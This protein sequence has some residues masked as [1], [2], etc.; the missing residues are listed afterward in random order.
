MSN[1]FKEN[2]YLNK[3]TEYFSIIREDI[4]D[5]VPN[6]KENI[7]L[8]IGCGDGGTLFKLKSSH[9]A[10][11]IVGVEINEE[12]V[13][14]SKFKLDKIIIN[15]IETIELPFEFKSFD[16]IILGDVIEHLINPWK[17]LDKLAHYLKDDGC[18][19]C[20]IPNIRSWKTIKNL[21]LGEWKYENSGLMDFGHLRYFC[22]NDI[23]KMFTNIGFQIEIIIKKVPT[24]FRYY[25]TKCLVGGIHELFITQYLFLAKKNNIKI[26]TKILTKY[27]NE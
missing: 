12:I 7:I 6:K 8:E 10:S 16:I 17:L 3:K 5:L 25:I 14:N 9:K 4:I 11:Q 23:I 2:I 13:K 26:K 1:S 18:F 27:A 21:V 24:K 19:I 22:L 20:S 15:D